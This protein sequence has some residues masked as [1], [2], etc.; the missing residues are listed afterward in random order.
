[1]TTDIATVDTGN[2]YDVS[3]LNAVQHGILSRH[4]VLPWEEKSEYEALAALLVEE[5]RPQGITEEHLVGELAGVIWRKTRLRGAEKAAYLLRLNHVLHDSSK[6]PIKAVLLEDSRDQT[7]AKAAITASTDKTQEDLKRDTAQLTAFNAALAI[8]ATGQEDAYQQALATIPA[9]AREV[10]PT[11][12]RCP[13]NR[14]HDDSP[15]YQANAESLEI[16]INGHV[17]SH[18]R[19]IRELENRQAIKEQAIGQSFLVPDKIEP[20]NRYEVHLDRKFERTLS[21]LVKLQDMRKP[22]DP[23]PAH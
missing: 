1:M 6:S 20:L 15:V 5:Y 8:L 11:W 19:S 14:Y 4:A 2:H 10:W 18:E 9:G 3:K 23:P 22:S 7:A 21:M 12:I 16:W 13:I 17:E